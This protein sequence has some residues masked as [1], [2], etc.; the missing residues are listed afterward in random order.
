MKYA[1][2][3]LQ[4]EGDIASAKKIASSGIGGYFAHPCVGHMIEHGFHTKDVQKFVANSRLQI[5]DT[6][7]NI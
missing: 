3:L 1:C 7:M 2:T 5:P 6:E 4:D